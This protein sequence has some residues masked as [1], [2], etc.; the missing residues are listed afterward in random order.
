MCKCLKCGC[1]VFKSEI[2]GDGN[3]E[4]YCVMCG[5]DVY[6]RQPTDRE[7]EDTNLPEFKLGEYGKTRKIP[8]ELLF[9]EEVETLTE[10]YGVSRNAIECRRKIV[11][12][13]M[14][15]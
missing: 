1:G 12:K 3:D 14:G 7:R 5:L 4:Y 9:E 13:Q 15:I 10:R 2:G 11:R 8:T 6:M